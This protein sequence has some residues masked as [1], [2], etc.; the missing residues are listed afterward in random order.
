[1]ATLTGRTIAASYAE[2]LKTTSASGITGSLDTVQDGDATDSALQ[3]S[4]GGVKSTG[5]LEVTGAATLST[6]VTLATGATVTGI[7]NADLVTGSATLLATQGAIKTYVDAQVATSDTL[8]EVLAIGN[9]TG[10]T[11]IVVTAG[12]SITTDTISETTSAAGVTIDSVLVKDNAVTAT[13]FTGALDGNSSTATKVYVTDNESTA[14]ANLIS[15][16]ADAATTTGNHGLE[17][18][19]DLTYTPSTGTVTAAV[20]VG[21]LT[22][23][24]SGSAATVTGATQASITTCANL[25]TTGTVT[26][27]TWGTGA[28]IGGATVTLG[29][30]ATGDVYYRNASGVFTRLG[31]GTDADV[32]T[33][34]SGIPSWVAPTVGDITGVTAGAGLTGGGTSGT[35]TLNAIGTTD[36]ITVNADDIDIASTYVG[37]TSITTVGTIGTGVWEGT[38]VA[39]A[40]GGTGS[41]TAGAARAA[42]DVDAAGT[43]NSTNVTLAGTPDYITIDAATQVITRGDV[44]LSADV[45]GNLP[46]GNQNSGTDASAT[47][48]WRGDGTWVTPGGSGTVTGTG[49]DNQVAVWT[50]SSGIEGTSSLV[51]DGTNLEVGAGGTFTTASGNDLN[52]VYPDNRSLFIKEGSTTHVTVDNTGSVGIGGTPTRPLHVFSANSAAISTLCLQNTTSTGDASIWFREPSSE[53]AVGLD[54]S[55]SNSFKISYSSELGSN[56]RLVVAAGGRVTVKK[57]SNSEFATL[58]SSFGIVQIDLDDSNNFNLSLDEDMELQNPAGTLVPGQSG[59]IVITQDGGDFDISAWGTKWM[60]EGG[61]PPSI[62]TTDGDV[63]NLVY[64]VAS[65]DSIHAVLLKAFAASA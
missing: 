33:L 54:N 16:V 29:S 32:L 17:M 44:D 21:A 26:S 36:R 27:G 6:S 45:T 15:F 11:S 41:T 58:T 31:V 39:V 9:T 64:F 59:C 56:D 42:L 52:L 2:L 40:Q 12:Q 8:A 46:V 34:A 60:F 49:A 24:A 20:F 28:V 57:S 61:T 38:A 35:V 22:G 55:D 62:S 48:F 3:L 13:T 14:E 63:D 25:T 53:W 10:S 23:N 51:F 47:T 30:D 4:S 5:T 1:M 43:D 7:D 18:D 65:A 19:G 37:Q 50:S